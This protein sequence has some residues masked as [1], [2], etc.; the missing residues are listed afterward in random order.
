[1]CV[2]VA[3][4]PNVWLD[5]GGLAFFIDDPVQKICH[6]PARSCFFGERRGRLVLAESCGPSKTPIGRLSVFKDDKHVCPVSL[7]GPWLNRAQQTLPASRL[8][9]TGVTLTH[10]AARKKVAKDANGGR[11]GPLLQVPRALPYGM[12]RQPTKAPLNKDDNFSL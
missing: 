6:L 3:L 7:R 2:G 10:R 11:N 8:A 1:M 12:A 9:P 5:I 4:C